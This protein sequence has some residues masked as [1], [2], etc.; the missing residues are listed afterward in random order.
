MPVSVASLIWVQTT[1]PLHWIIDT[2]PFFL[3]LF[4]SLAGSRQ[5]LL[6]QLNT[7]LEQKIA[8]RTVALSKTNQELGNEI[9]E[10]TRAKEA[11]QESEQRYRTISELVSDYAYIARLNADNTYELE[12][13]T[14]AF[15]R[16]IG[17]VP[18][19]G[20]HSPESWVP[21]I[22]P[23]DL[24]RVRQ[25]LQRLMVGQ[26]EVSEFRIV[27][28]QGEVRWVREY[29]HP[30]WDE[31]QGRVMRLYIAGHDITESKQAEKALRMSEARKGAILEFALDCI[32]SMDD[33][34]KII[35]FNP[36]AERTFGY[37]RA[38]VMGQAMADCLIPPSLR[39][40]HH[41]GLVQYFATGE[42][43]LLGKRIE[44]TAMRADGSEFPVEMAII[45]L[46]LTQDHLR[47]FHRPPSPDITERKAV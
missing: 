10:R 32:V 34:G 17:F 42:G 37:L 40:Q 4:A 22:Y 23:E 30:V 21:F 39:E 18:D 11:L 25:R 38:E 14:E 7:Q 33:G 16:V 26:A 19:L 24:S 27:N 8:D 46:R 6:S 43:P 36:A 35:E 15:S 28:T 13:V 31:T 12:W 5:D 45:P 29:G 44:T 20:L 41:R 2:A 1:Q 3:G 47:C 9:I